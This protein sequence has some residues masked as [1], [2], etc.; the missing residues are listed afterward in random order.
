VGGVW[1]EARIPHSTEAGLWAHSALRASRS[2]EVQIYVWQA[3][4]RASTRLTAS[5]R[6]PIAESRGG[7]C[8][9]GGSG[10]WLAFLR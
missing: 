9:E 3:T 6:R 4:I 10:A 8:I 1:N 5:S 2:P 7:C